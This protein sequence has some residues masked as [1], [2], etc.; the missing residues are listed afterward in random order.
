MRIGKHE[1]RK[2]RRPRGGYIQKNVKIE[3]MSL[4]DF[5]KWETDFA[6]ATDEQSNDMDVQKGL[7]EVGWAAEVAARGNEEDD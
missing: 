1:T 2:R 6:E 4:D 5:E 7:E 3:H